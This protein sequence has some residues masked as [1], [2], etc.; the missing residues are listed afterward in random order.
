M[1]TAV[2]G[3]LIGPYMN[4]IHLCIRIRIRACCILWIPIL[5]KTNYKKNFGK[6]ILCSCPVF[7]FFFF[8][9]FFFFFFFFFFLFLFLFSYIDS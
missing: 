3:V 7:F 4:L 1:L 6:N 9:L 2:V 5:Y 8:L